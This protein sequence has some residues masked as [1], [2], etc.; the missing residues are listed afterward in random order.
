MSNTPAIEP[1]DAVRSLLVALCG[2]EYASGPVCCDGAQID[3]LAA[4]LKKAEPL[5]ALC[6]ACKENFFQL[7]CRFTCSP[8][9]SLF[10]NVTKSDTLGLGKLAV[11][12]LD[13]W[14]DPSFAE[15]FYDSCKG[16]KFGATNGYAMDLIGGG[17]KSFKEF[18]LFL[19]DEKPMLGGLPFQINYIW[20][21]VDPQ[22]PMTPSKPPLRFC[23][24]SDLSY[25]CS[26]ADC[27]ASCPE[28]PPVLSGHSCTINGISCF[29]IS[30]IALYAII[31]CVFLIWRLL[32][33]KKASPRLFE[34][35]ITNSDSDLYS[36]EGSSIGSRRLMPHKE[37]YVINSILERWFGKSAFYC[38][39]YPKTT[40]FT[41]LGLASILTCCSVFVELEKDPVNLWVSPLAQAYKEKTY[42]DENFGP[43]YRTQQLFLYNTSGPVVSYDTFS[44]WFEIEREMLALSAT[45]EDN[46][47]TFEDICFKPTGDACL[48]ESATQ[49]F[50]GVLP[51]E[52]TWSSDLESCAETPVE[53]L[54]PFQQ[55]LKKDLLFGQFNHSVLSAHSLVSTLLVNNAV[56]RSSDVV[57][58][59]EAWEAVLESYLL[60]LRQKAEQRGLS[61]AFSTELSL[62]KELS[63]DTLKD[64]KIVVGSYLVMFI[65]VAL[66]LGHGLPN[67]SDA[68]LFVHTKIGIALAG[69]FIV[70]LSVGSSVGLF[71]LIGVKSTLIIAEVIPFLVLAVGVD[72]IFL[73]SHE[74]QH[75]NASY[76]NESVPERISRA[77]G[78]IAPS[79][80][81]SGTTQTLAFSLGTVVA[82]PA[83]R[84]FALYA[85][86]AVVFNAFLQLTALV[87]LFGLDQKRTEE[88]R[89]D[90]WP[91]RKIS[92]EE[93]GITLL[94][95][96]IS[97]DAP[98][99]LVFST[100]LK[101]YYAP[102]VLQKRAK[103]LIIAGFVLWLGIL[104][105]LLPELQ[106]G[107]DQRDAIPTGL[108]LIEYFNAMY[109]Y[110]NV[111]A[112]VYFVVRGLDV[113]KREQQRKL[114]GRF[115]TCNE[116]SLANIL[117]QERKRSN[118]STIAEPAASWIDDFFLWLNPELDECCRWKKGTN[119]TEICPPFGLP[120]MCET[121]Y[122]HKPWDSTMEYFPEDGD[123]M[124]YFKVWIDS[125][126][127]PCPLGGKAPYGTSVAYDDDRISASVF[128]SSHT[129]LRS[130]ND[131][132]QGYHESLR[133]TKELNKAISTDSQENSPLV[134]AYLPFYIF[135]VQYETIKRLTCMLLGFALCVIFI[136]S[137]FLLGSFRTS[138]VLC[139]T[140]ALILTNVLGAMVVLGIS[141]NAVSLVNLVIIVGLAVEFCAHVARAFTVVDRFEYRDG[142][143]M[144]SKIQRLYYALIGVGGLVFGGIF[145]TKLIGVGVLAFASSKIFQVY[146]FRMWFALVVIAAVHSLCLLPV[147]LS[148]WGGKYYVY[149]SRASV[150]L[151]DLADRLRS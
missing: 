140:V 103:P 72:N 74:L 31:P 63:K 37:V 15:G 110:L 92:V 89:L 54:P 146:Y 3:A 85:A 11:A 73:I 82:M 119:E 6:P 147:M 45:F 134:F 47:V 52:K 56:D 51:D 112:P 90:M 19:G 105:A 139:L 66:A 124:R 5:I 8:D 114:C 44:W 95:G 75:I 4:N 142:R 79:I 71:A 141:L 104:L 113:T 46:P 96:Q 39:F 40:I 7:F 76:P 111:G 35:P 65:Y 16:V 127:E 94:G 50:S 64:I 106:L 77:I 143:T 42:F 49:Y 48:I 135:F 20:E 53:C 22:L 1:S 151:D 41:T 130:Q 102:V 86:A 132:I 91:W 98:Q 148:Y 25:R 107:L 67:F 101:S 57:R 34:E 30:V 9:Q 43:F 10:V 21:D 123:F 108:Y 18:F 149:S 84:N 99:E 17:A 117:E 93:T 70:F 60:D 121:C 128:R 38:S 23:N 125:P 126:S 131:F 78:R 83:V 27:P 13:M 29:L 2:E 26:C 32:R 59:A 144:G 122:A 145:M 129:P 133:I 33:L 55:P 61:L 150:V 36:D 116:F 12:E 137:S 81:L 58:K 115:T 24:D 100:I 136:T 14:V 120:R 28:L 138:A 62:E 97:L 118:I 109:A 69:I 87:A 80:V 68:A 88:G